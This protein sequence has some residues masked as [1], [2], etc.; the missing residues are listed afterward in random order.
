MTRSLVGLLLLAAVVAGEDGDVSTLTVAQRLEQ[1]VDLPTPKQRSA[2]ARALAKD[3]S[4]S[5]DAWLRA[6]RKFGRFSAVRPGRHRHTVDLLVEGKTERTELAAYV[7]KSYR[8]TRPARLLVVLH[9][10]GGHGTG[11]MSMWLEWA[12]TNGALL[13]APTEAGSAGGYTFASR[14]RVAALAA[15]RWMRRRYNVDENRIY[16]AGVSRGGHLT[17]DLALR[18]RDRFAA[19]VPAVGS[20]RMTT[21]K[22]QN[23]LRYLD[24]VLD[25]PIRDLQGLGD[26]PL[27]IKTLR[28]AFARLKERGARDAKFVEFPELG[29]SF[30]LDT[31]DWNQFL[32]VKRDPLA[33]RIIRAAAAPGEG[34]MF[35]MEITRTKRPVAET[36]K[37]SMP[38]SQYKALDDDGLRLHL[39]NEADRRTARLEVTRTSNVFA[40]KRRHVATFRLLLCDAWIPA[41]RDPVIVD[42]GSRSVKRRPARSARVLLTE[43]AERM[44][45]TFLPTAELR[46]P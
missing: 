29:H 3:D 36:F 23:N 25:L 12:E 9:G 32:A 41:R 10:S 43:F 33:P 39:Q 2:A 42:L 4:V 40:V 46:L 20:P 13:L 17:W 5:I 24:N 21:A 7:P 11:A 45:R 34:R 28:I 38:Q 35:W 16:L 14:E 18:F 15:L 30:R 19:I 26:H 27:M 37:V 44:D 6:M 31:E 22:R 8:A 1:L